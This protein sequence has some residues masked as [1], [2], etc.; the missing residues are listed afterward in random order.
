M[1]ATMPKRDVCA[2]GSDARNAGIR[3]SDSVRILGQV[4]YV[5]NINDMRAF[6]VVRCKKAVPDRSASSA[7]LPLNK[8]QAPKPLRSA[9]CPTYECPL[10]VS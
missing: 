9:T 7:Q 2:I 1:K 4:P 5:C 3:I 8:G 6:G 10:F